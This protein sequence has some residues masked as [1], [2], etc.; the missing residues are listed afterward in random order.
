MSTTTILQNRFLFFVFSQFYF[1]F[2]VVKVYGLKFGVQHGRHGSD[3][4]NSE[5]MSMIFKFEIFSFITCDYTYTNIMFWTQS[6]KNWIESFN[7][8]SQD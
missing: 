1:F 4:T 6:A 3:L 7:F 5:P 8:F 2:V